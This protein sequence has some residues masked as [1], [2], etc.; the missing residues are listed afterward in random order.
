MA[1]RIASTAL[2]ACCSLAFGAD[3]EP[4][5]LPHCSPTQYD[6][7]RGD[8]VVSPFF[9]DCAS[10]LNVSPDALKDAGILTKVSLPVLEDSSS[11]MLLFGDVALAAGDQN[12]TELQLLA[13]VTWDMATAGLAIYSTPKVVPKFSKV[14]LAWAFSGLITHGYF[15]N[16]LGSSGWSVFKANNGVPSLEKIHTM[17]NSTDCR[18]LFD[19]V[20][21]TIKKQPHQAIDQN[22]TDIHAFENITFDVAM[23]WLELYAHYK[24]DSIVNL[25][26][27]FRSSQTTLLVGGFLVAAI[28]LAVAAMVF[29]VQRTPPKASTEERVRLLV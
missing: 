9:N 7:L 22:D 16:C 20:Q 29:A 21:Y 27:V 25:A 4:I 28:V 11:C 2:L 13:N 3:V 12:C 15:Y 10:D 19:R 18:S 26:V 23:D 14:G 24:H 1:L 17:R 5:T 6:S 8:A